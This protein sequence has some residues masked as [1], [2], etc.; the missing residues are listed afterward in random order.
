M[1]AKLLVPASQ[2]DAFYWQLHATL[3]HADTTAR[4]IDDFL[5]Q[6]GLEGADRARVGEALRAGLPMKPDDIDVTSIAA[7]LE[8]TGVLSWTND[9]RVISS[10]VAAD[11]EVSLATIIRD[12][13]R[14]AM[15]APVADALVTETSRALG[16]L[17]DSSTAEALRRAFISTLEHDLW[18]R[19]TEADRL[20]DRIIAA[21]KR[22]ARIATDEAAAPQSE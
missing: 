10:R 21:I 18:R 11:L 8:E 6:L 9:L 16:D 5:T 4:F 17:I 3:D 13:P 22:H 20:A 1:T 7:V 2:R 15:P 19:D 14:G 12:A